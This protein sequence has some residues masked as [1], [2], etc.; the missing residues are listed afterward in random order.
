MKFS[1]DQHEI[2]AHLV[3]RQLPEVERH[4]CSHYLEGFK[5]LAMPQ[6]QIPSLEQLNRVLTPRTGWQTVRTR[7][8]YSDAVPWYNA[9]AKKHFLITDYMRTWDEVDF[10]PE[11]DM[12]HDIFGHIPFMA[13]PEY[14][15]LQE[16]FAPA[17]FQADEAQR[18]DIKRLAWFSTEFGI[19]RQNGEFKIFGAGLISSN[20][21]LHR[22]INGDTALQPFTLDNVLSHDKA[23]WDFNETLF[24]FDSIHQL[25]VEL[26]KYF[27]VIFSQSKAA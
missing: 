5:L 26:N 18:E 7:V 10:T 2:W 25:K 20:A 12:F 3:A 4:A 23:V 1:Q 15:N 21:E 19:L 22:V 16:L 13:L 8:R 14:T 27:Q 17:F 6:D 9:F 11:P 24:W